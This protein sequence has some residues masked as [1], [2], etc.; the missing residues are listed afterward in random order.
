M[1]FMLFTATAALVLKIIEY[2][3][4]GSPVLLVIAIVLLGLA[5]FVIFEAVLAIRRIFRARRN[6]FGAKG[7]HI[8]K[9]RR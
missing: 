2:S 1:I 7:K 6:L 4:G 8:K 9:G 5:C 3:R